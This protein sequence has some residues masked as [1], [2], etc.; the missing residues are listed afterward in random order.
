MG[1]FRG[2][3][4]DVW[5]GGHR[6]PFII[7]WPGQVEENTQSDE[8]ISQV[9][10][11]ATLAS[12]TGI[13]LPANAAPDSYDIS[14]V[15]LGK[16]YDS[17]LRDA[18]IHNTYETIWGIRKGDWL[19]INNSTGGHRQMPESFKDLTGYTDFHTDGLLFYMKDDSEQRKNLFMEYPE[20]VNE[21]ESLI[22]EY[23]SSTHTARRN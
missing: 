18:T 9:D 17:P 2:L 8:V 6:V 3:K 14:A 4:R 5:E 22:E 11:M 20:K 23:R 19:Y 10:L 1:N 16:E 15:I 7:K 13:E 12:I 21:M